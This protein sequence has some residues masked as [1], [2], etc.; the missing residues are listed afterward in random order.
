MS[1]DTLWTA[2]GATHKIVPGEEIPEDFHRIVEYGL[3]SSQQ[4]PYVFLSENYFNCKD[5]IQW[6]LP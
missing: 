3:L 2:T 4:D 1:V 5:S 6:K